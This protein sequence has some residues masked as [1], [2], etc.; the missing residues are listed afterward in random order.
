M[1]KRRVGLIALMLCV[2]LFRLPYAVSAASTT[3]AKEPID[4]HQ[5]CALTIGYGY[6]GTPFPG[7]TVNLYKA[8]DVSA[9]FQYTLTAAFAP[10]QL[11][12]NGIQTNSEWDAIR[13]TLEAYILGNAIQPVAT[14]V[15]DAE[16]KAHFAVPEP[17]LYFASAVS[18]VQDDLTCIFDSALVALPGLGTD[19]LWQY[20][21]SVNAKPQILPPITPDEK[22][23]WKVIKLWKGEAKRPQSVEVEIFRNGE[24]YATVTLSEQNYWSYHWTAPKDGADWKVVER[25]VP[26]GY[27]M[28]V[29]QQETTFVVTNT[30]QE[31]PEPSPPKTGDSANILLYTILLYVS[32]TM[33]VILGI[34]GK[35]N[36]HEET[37]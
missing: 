12:L 5:E 15:T 16:G 1:A 9:D 25:N 10:S 11:I 35:R 21:I 34:A 8:A 13:T 3:D 31:E 37:K 36:R 27:T 24:S 18:I 19:G 2:C 22:T 30:Y 29:I 7:Q 28:T 17:G 32:G 4:T 26:S 14:A 20:Q 23:E 6:D 33:L